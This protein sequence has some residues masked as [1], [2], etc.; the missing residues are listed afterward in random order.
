M[1]R[2]AAICISTAMAA[3][4]NSRILALRKEWIDCEVSTVLRRELTTYPASTGFSKE[5]DVRCAQCT[6][7]STNTKNKRAHTFPVGELCSSV[8]SPWLSGLPS[9]T[10]CIFV[11]RG[12][13]EKPFNGWSKSKAQLDK[14]IANHFA[15][16]SKMVPSRLL[17]DSLF[18]STPFICL[19]QVM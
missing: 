3:S 19:S 18:L 14:E 1:G 17:S 15:N 10:S 5:N 4:S 13:V 16:V 8:L 2:M 7:P 9:T 6:I 12:S 11:A